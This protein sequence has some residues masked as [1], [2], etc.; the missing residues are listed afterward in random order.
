MLAEPLELVGWRRVDAVH[1]SVDVL[2]PGHELLGEDP[3]L[4]AHLGDSP[5][6]DGVE[7]IGDE[8]PEGGEPISAPPAPPHDP[9]LRAV[10]DAVNATDAALVTFDVFDT[11]VFRKV[12]KPVD[13]FALVGGRLRDLGLLIAAMT[14]AMFGAVRARSERSGRERR[15][16]I[17]GSGETDLRGIYD[18]FPRWPLAEGVTTDELVAN[19]LSVERDLLA[20]DLEVVAFLEGVKKD[21]RRIAAISDTYF[22]K[23]ALRDLLQ[24]PRLTTLLEEVELHASCELGFGKGSGLWKRTEEMLGVVPE[25]IVHFGDNPVDDVEKARAEGVV[26][27][28]FAQRDEAPAAIKATEHRLRETVARPQSL[29]LRNTI[30]PAGFAAMRGKVAAH[31]HEQARRPYWLYGA[32]VL[33]PV[34]SGFAQWV[35]REAA[36]AGM[37]RVGCLMREGTLL[38]ELVS[39][40]AAVEG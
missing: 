35:A 34:L 5:R 4:A 23:E 14:P 9:R 3:A 28:L 1:L 40:A 33:G 2:C 38:A 21:G 20:A 32:T 25:R 26:A 31:A 19:E 39:A 27:L 7:H 11:L 17:D 15:A 6:A 10:A 30:E 18:A 29:E 16:G 24:L 37:T 22:P 13:A 8:R 36:W 12:D